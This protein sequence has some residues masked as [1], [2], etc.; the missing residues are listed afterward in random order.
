MNSQFDLPALPLLDGNT[1]FLDNSRYEYFTTCQRKAEY[2]VVRGRVSADT[3]Q[4]LTFGECIH[5]A[6]KFRYKF[7]GNQAVDAT[8]ELQQQILIDKFYSDKV[9]PLQDHRTPAFAA[10]VIQKYNITYGQEPFEL[11]VSPSGRTLVEEGF[12]FEIGR[13]GNIRVVW[14]G[15][16]D[17]AIVNSQGLWVVDHKTSSV[18]GEGYFRE[19]MNSSQMLGYAWALQ[20][21]YQQ[22]CA[23][24]IINAHF[25]RK[26]TKTGKGIEF[27]RYPIAFDQERINEWVENTLYVVSDF[28]HSHERGYF[29]MHTKQCVGKFGA[30]EFFDVCSLVPQARLSTL[31]GSL[32]KE[33]SFS[34]LHEDAINLDEIAATPP[35]AGWKPTERVS[36]DDLSASYLK[37]LNV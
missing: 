11:A 3:K 7:S 12:S 18:G 8:R 19:F 14:T 37:D 30:C 33:D 10:D 1:L 36:P 4:A 15:R 2:A 6:Q 5:L 21:H 13:I 22:P 26:P 27:A 29:A 28:L 25:V 35:P 32:Y 34:P 31:Y 17:L 24:V 23:G 9:V 20:Q 16:I